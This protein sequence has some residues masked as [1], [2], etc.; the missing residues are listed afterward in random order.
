MRILAGCLLV[1]T[2][3]VVIAPSSKELHRRYGA[4]D[5]QIRGEKNAPA[6]ETFTAR[7]G[8]NLSVRYGS[9]H[10]AC[11]I[12]ITPAQSP[13]HQ[14]LSPKQESSSMSS[15]DVSEILEDVAPVSLRGT[16]LSAGGFQS[17]CANRYVT[18]YENVTVM[19]GFNGCDLSNPNHDIGT[20]IIYKRDIC[21][22]PDAP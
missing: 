1:A 19:R 17:S 13:D 18:E 8:I 12:S 10:R 3:G 15:K 7:P 20:T 2:A 21:P 14:E 4:P 6:I 5:S 11:K 22:K 9:D 16:K